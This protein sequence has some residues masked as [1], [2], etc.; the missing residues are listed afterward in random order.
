[1]R[2]QR[3]IRSRLYGV[4]VPPV[5][6]IASVAL[7]GVLVLAGMRRR[8]AGGVVL[9]VIGG[10]LAVRGLTGRCPL[11]RM[12]AL[13]K[14]V[15]VRRAV[16]VE[17][18]PREIYELW[19]DLRNLPRFLSHVTSIELED[20]GVSRWTIEEGPLHL[21]WRAQLVEDTPGHRLRW[22][23]LD[24]DLHHDGALELRPGPAGRGTIVEVKIH[25]RPRGG[26]LVFGAFA[27]LLR[28]LAGLRLDEELAR[29][30][31]LVET[32]EPITAARNPAEAE[33]EA[34]HAFAGG[35]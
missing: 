25:V 23:T 9:A 31:A 11:Y 1:M 28:Q 33:A 27:G 5:E 32:G 18:S 12:R 8:T 35:A 20:G 7:G 21:S 22:H 24:G 17:A 34:S 29:M 19:R 15:T 3:V 4:N 14:G 13:T 6:R 10:G 26:R 2:T 30:R 16:T